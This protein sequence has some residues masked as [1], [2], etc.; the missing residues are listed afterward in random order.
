MNFPYPFSYTDEKGNSVKDFKFEAPVG[1]W[2]IIW[3][4]FPYFLKEVFY[5][6]FKKGERYSP[7]QW[8]DTMKR[9]KN[10]LSKDYTNN[11][12]FPKEFK[13]VDDAV[14]QQFKERK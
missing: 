10:D 12:I 5:N 8:L 3:S 13:K 6:V 2:R 9:Y 11:E 7:E 14:K 1:P 4:N